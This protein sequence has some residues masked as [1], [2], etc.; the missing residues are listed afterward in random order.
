MKDILTRARSRAISIDLKELKQLTTTLIQKE[1]FKY[2]LITH[3]KPISNDLLITLAQ[4]KATYPYMKVIVLTK[5]YSLD[6]VTKLT[7]VEVDYVVDYNQDAS[8]VA[9]KI[10]E[11]INQPAKTQMPRRQID[12]L[13]LDPEKRRVTRS[14]EQINLRKMEFN[15]LEFL[16]QNAGKVFNR[17]ELMQIV[18]DYRYESFTNTVDVHMAKL[19]KK[20]DSG[21]KVKLIHTVHGKGYKLDKIKK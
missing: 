7:E 19:R 9:K 21:R 20:I 8:I 18:W 1:K 4:F 10:A 11:I 2:L 12:D 6:K 13:V 3:R 17:T 14:G 15:L 16:M 5:D